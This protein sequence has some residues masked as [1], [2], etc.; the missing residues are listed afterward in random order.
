MPWLFTLGLMFLVFKN[1]SF[2][3]SADISNFWYNI[4]SKSKRKSPERDIDHGR[5]HREAHL[6]D[7]RYGTIQ[8][9]VWP[10]ET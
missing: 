6:P 5:L 3:E 2:Q 9:A 8:I 7:Y 10:F 4:I 1:T